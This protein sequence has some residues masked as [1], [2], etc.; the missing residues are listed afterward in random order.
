ICQRCPDILGKLKLARVL[1]L[2]SHAAAGIDQEIRAEVCF[3]LVFLDVVTIRLTVRSPVDVPNLVARIVLPMLGEL[4]P[5]TLIRRLVNAGEEPFN[6]S[7]RDK[8]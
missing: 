8:G 5:E 2:I 1:P 3:L 6:E 7:A 4:D